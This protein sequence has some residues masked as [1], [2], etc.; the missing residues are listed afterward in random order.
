MAAARGE[1]VLDYSW[2]FESQE[3]EKEE[4]RELRRRVGS[5]MNISAG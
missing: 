5:L 2:R 1:F 4:G 3:E